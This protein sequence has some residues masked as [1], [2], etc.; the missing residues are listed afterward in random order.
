M[1]TTFETQLVHGYQNYFLENNINA[2]A[3]RYRQLLWC[4]QFTDI[5]V[6]SDDKDYYL[7]IE[8]KSIQTK[9]LYFSAHFQ[10]DQV[11]NMTKFLNLSGRKG[12]LALEY[13]H[14]GM[15]SEGYLIPWEIVVDK[16]DSNG[17]G[18]TKEDIICQDG[19][20]QLIR[21]KNSYSIPT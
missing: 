16:F 18:I 7:G 12:Y 19:V 5:A 9:K 15:K 14:R 11:S 3:Y 6:D 21:G 4:G 1:A 2:V 20:I 17:K 13:R 8:C 10:E